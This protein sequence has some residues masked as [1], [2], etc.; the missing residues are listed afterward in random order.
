MHGINIVAELARRFAAGDFDSAF[1]LYHPRVR[2]EQPSSLPHGGIH[3]GHDGVRAMGATFA[4]YWTRT[5][6]EPTRTIC[7]DGRLLQLTTQ[8]W[9]AKSTGRCASM[10][11]LELFSFAGNMVSEIRVFQHDTHRLLATLSQAELLDL[12]QRAAIISDEPLG[13]TAAARCSGAPR[14]CADHP[15]RAHGPGRTA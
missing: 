9:S 15:A 8:T 3:E 1:A 12:Q 5:I 7:G 10:D 14:S 6:S 11:V 4:K 13:A 2:I